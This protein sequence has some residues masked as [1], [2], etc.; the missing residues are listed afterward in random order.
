MGNYQNTRHHKGPRELTTGGEWLY[1]RN[2]VIEA[3]RAGRRTFT[4][5]ILPPASKDESDEIASLRLT[6]LQRHIII[7]SADRDHLDR[8]V[9]GGHIRASRLRRPAI[10][11]LTS[12]TSRRRRRPTRTRSSLCSTILRI[13]RTSAP[14]FARHV[15]R[16]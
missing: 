6:A 4:E 3:L 14:S 12:R 9:R 7:R 1:G 16:A 15:R 8:L 5:I 2:P 13:R 10:H 11:M